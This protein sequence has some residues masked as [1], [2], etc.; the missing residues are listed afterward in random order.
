MKIL[1]ASVIIGLFLESDGAIII[2]EWAKTKHKLIVP[3]GVFLELSD[4]KEGE[5]YSSFVKCLKSKKILIFRELKEKESEY[6]KKRYPYLGLGEIEVIYWGSHKKSNRSCYSV[7]DDLA[8]RKAALNE[9]IQITGTIGLVNRL[10]EKGCIEEKTRDK[11]FTE[12]KRNGFRFPKN[13][14]L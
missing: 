14:L 6:L 7:I 2:E 10:V 5:P 3:N 12:L 11:I 13:L 9:R 1:D 8:A 4:K